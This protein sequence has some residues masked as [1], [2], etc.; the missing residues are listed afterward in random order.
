MSEVRRPAYDRGAVAEAIG[1][2]Q[3]VQQVAEVAQLLRVAVA[4]HESEAVA[5]GEEGR[6]YAGGLH[7]GWAEGLRHASGHLDDLLAQWRSR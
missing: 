2:G 7:H 6:E 5:A 3:M 4:D 1:R